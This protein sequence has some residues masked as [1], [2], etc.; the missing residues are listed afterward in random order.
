M[1]LHTVLIEGLLFLFL[2]QGFSQKC[3]SGR[4][5]GD[6]FFRIYALLSIQSCNSNE[7]RYRGVA[8]AE[9][10]KYTI[11]EANR[12]LNRSLFGYT[13]YDIDDYENLDYTINATV[14]M[15][16]SSAKKIPNSSFKFNFSNSNKFESTTLGLVGLPT[17]ANAIYAQQAFSY[18]NIPIISYSATSDELSDK[19]LYP[20]FYRTVPPDVFQVSLFSDLLKYFNWT[21]VSIV[22]SD[23]SYGR[24][25]AFQLN[26]KLSEIGVCVSSQDIITEQND[27]NEYLFSNIN[28]DPRAKVVIYWGNFISLKLLLSES[29]KRKLFDKVWLLSEGVGLE[30]W[31]IEFIKTFQ[32]SIM[33]LNPF[34]YIEENFKQHFLNITYKNAS[35]WLRTLLERKGANEVNTEFTVSNIATLFDYR[36]VGYL[37]TSV[38]VLIRAFMNYMKDLC[39]ATSCETLVSITNR[40]EFNQKVKNVSFSFKFNDVF[41]FN[42][43]QDPSTASYDLFVVTDSS[44][45]HSA[46]WS[47]GRGLNVINSTILKSFQI[48]SACSKPCSP[49]QYSEY[50]KEKSCCWACITC[51]DNQVQSAIGQKECIKCKVEEDYISNPNRTECVK[52]KHIYWRFSTN[53]NHMFVT[54]SFSITG[55]AITVIF[56]LTFILKRNTPIVK[57]SNFWMSMMQMTLHFVL[58]TV[59]FFAIGEESYWKCVSTM[60]ISGILYYAIITLTWLK[61]KHLVAVFGTFHKMGKKDLQRIRFR[62][63]LIFLVANLVYVLI[64]L[65]I[66][67]IKPLQ[68]S[69]IIDKSALTLNR[70]CKSETYRLVHVGCVLILLIF[71]AIELFRGRNLPWK[72]DETRYIALGTFSS[73]LVKIMAIPLGFSLSDVNNYK[74]MLYTIIN[75]SNFLLLVASYIF[76]LKT[77]WFHPE[78]NTRTDFQRNHRKIYPEFSLTA[79]KEN[80]S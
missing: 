70:I 53:P 39:N 23:D 69:E 52:L 35:P 37:Q 20:N 66:E 22:A 80:I 71:C 7:T 63:F 79:K 28:S 72:Y 8:Q 12:Q 77:I 24:S 36:R 58:F 32:G 25:G 76:K 49:G 68:V 78:K 41:Q 30:N 56:M 10:L 61:V 16:L 19:T 55:A 64:M 27:E 44:F 33:M 60:H 42:E 5:E 54:L 21:Y 38:N 4:M 17:S 62:E 67:T 46:S 29:K 65:V 34:T 15:F 31:L 6:G 18:I 2:N 75:L 43:K 50:T 73:I 1:L 57:A 74:V 40:K 11:D 59:T 48:I 45:M 9:A 14:D 26:L 51:P 13:I 3:Q 47:S